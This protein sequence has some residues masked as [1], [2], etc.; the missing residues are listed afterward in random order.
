MKRILCLIL[1]CLTIGFLC[2]G[3]VHEKSGGNVSEELSDTET[4]T[5]TKT[6]I[7]PET[8]NG[9]LSLIANGASDYKIIVSSGASNTIQALALKVWEGIREKT[10][11]RLE[12]GDDMIIESLGMTERETEILIGESNRADSQAVFNGLRY[13]DYCVA[14]RGKKL[15]I[16]GGSESAL[17]DAVDS[18]LE[19]IDAQTWLDSDNVR[20][21]SD[22]CVSY[23][24]TYRYTAM[25]LNGKDIAEYN[26]VYPKSDAYL[27]ASASRLVQTIGDL[28]GYVPKLVAD[29]KTN[30]SD[31][32]IYIGNIGTDAGFSQTV[33]DREI[34]AV[35]IL[36]NSMR[37][38]GKERQDTLEGIRKVEEYLLK[39]STSPTM[40]LTA[41]QNIPLTV[42]TYTA[43]SFN[44]LATGFN[45]RK[46]LVRDAI[47]SAMPD[48]VG[49]QE[50]NSQWRTYLED[51]LGQNGYARVGEI[52]TPSQTDGD[53]TNFTNSIYY[54]M[55]K[56]KLIETGTRMY[57]ETPDIMGSASEYVRN[58]AYTYA[59][60]EDKETG[61]RF[62]RTNT[63]FSFDDEKGYLY[64][65]EKLNGLFE[66][67]KEKYDIPYV[68]SG[69]YNIWKS[70]DWYKTM[71]AT[72]GWVDS[73]VASSK[74]EAIPDNVD[75]IFISPNTVLPLKYDILNC[76]YG[77]PY[78][79]KEQWDNGKTNG[80]SYYVSDHSP[81]ILTYYLP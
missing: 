4:G 22:M 55:D 49:V 65:I 34:L 40:Q 46:E 78:V 61:R 76:D 81:V 68:A 9:V 23:N 12:R 10:G 14:I 39:E 37:L 72:Y 53:W 26:I 16:A 74:L 24:G 80:Q 56:F 45:D 79:I 8:P 63:H 33:T 5:N 60:L 51:V 29:N 31:A 11:V 77:Y 19:K 38:V 48:T 50:E 1:A 75:Y 28:Y 70:W 30:G 59:V 41:S 66:E 62:L 2:I 32:N 43:M 57:S 36:G 18:F 20:Y 54:R 13:H 47:L 64:Q 35:Q 7:Q 58:R 52:F 42:K 15:I 71:T 25:T 3:C 73:N 27:K 21:T 6:D 17:A 67:M 69:D 44:V